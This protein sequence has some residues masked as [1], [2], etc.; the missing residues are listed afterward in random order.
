M[1]PT[2]GNFS[3]S[4]SG[5]AA[6]AVAGMSFVFVLFLITDGWLW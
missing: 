1:P 6:A 5:A 2:P 4:Y 3:P